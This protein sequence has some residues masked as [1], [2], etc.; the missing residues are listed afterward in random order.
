MKKIVVTNENFKKGT[1]ELLFKAFNQ[2]SMHTITMLRKFIEKGGVINKETLIKVLNFIETH[3]I[4]DDEKEFNKSL[5]L[6]KNKG[7]R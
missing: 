4:S 7:D 1:Q 5:L 2:G 3:L 6:L